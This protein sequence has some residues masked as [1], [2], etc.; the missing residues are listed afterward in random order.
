MPE[1]YFY[2]GG[3]QKHLTPIET[4]AAVM[5]TTETRENM[6][7]RSK[8]LHEKFGGRASDV[9]TGKDATVLPPE[10]REY[11]E[12]A[13]W[14]FTKADKTMATAAQLGQKVQGAEYVRRAYLQEDGQLVIASNQIYVTMN[15]KWS[16]KRCMDQLKSDNLKA[17]AEF[18]TP[19]NTFVAQLLRP[20]DIF[21]SSVQLMESKALSGVYTVAEPSLLEVIGT[22]QIPTNLQEFHDHIRSADGWTLAEGIAELGQGVSIAIVDN[23]FALAHKELKSQF[24]KGGFF[25]DVSDSSSFKEI[26]SNDA[27]SMPK[28]EHGTQC[29]GMAC[30]AAF[31]QPKGCGVAPKARLI[32]ISCLNDQIGSQTTLAAAIRKA[33]G[34]GADII[35]CSLGP[36]NST[37]FTMKDS[38][39]DAIEFAVD[40]GRGGKGTPVF[41]AIANVSGDLQEDEV[42]SFDKVIAVGKVDRSGTAGD[43]PRGEALSMVAPGIDVATITSS[44]KLSGTSFAAPI[45]AAVGAIGLSL[46]PDLEWRKLKELLEQSCARNEQPSHIRFDDDNHHPLYGH[47][48][49]DMKRLVQ[50]L[51]PSGGVA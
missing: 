35:S 20:A 11:F 6:G 28:N 37:A 41:W 16:R 10:A 51:V 44:Q 21:Q 39:R 27:S 17:V 36:S 46:K 34:F 32:P 3:K 18:S 42:C 31:N 29:A 9:T 5:P 33:V 1:T 7:W 24:S 47:G 38:L 40:E 23:G 19:K 48:R 15:S 45:A 13:D 2:Q 22:R 4:I 25:E 30:A 8:P 50:E 49:V 12:S 26:N 43:H 14:I